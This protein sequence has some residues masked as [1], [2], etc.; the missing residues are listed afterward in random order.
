MINSLQ[1]G[2]LQKANMVASKGQKAEM[3]LIDSNLLDKAV[4]ALLKHNNHSKAEN[5]KNLLLGSDEAIHVQFN[6]TRIPEQN[7]LSSRPIRIEIPHSLHKLNTKDDSDNEDEEND[8]LEE[9]EV[10]FIVKDSSKEWIQTLISQF[11]KQLSYIKKV[12]TLTSLRKKY[13]QYQDKRTLCNSYTLFLVDDAI[14][15][16]VGKLLG[17]TFFMKKKQPVPVKVS[18]KEALPFAVE[19]CIKSTF[20]TIGAGTCLSVK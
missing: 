11:P 18:R 8:A 19:K 17:K 6:L 9:V 14:L 10:C 3:K 5:D 1:K 16:M 13:G 4:G 12:L 2:N 15:P 20:M 7:S